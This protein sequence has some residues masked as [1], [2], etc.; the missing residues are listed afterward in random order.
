M[1]LDEYYRWAVGLTIHNGLDIET[2]IGT[3]VVSYADVTVGYTR[4]NSEGGIH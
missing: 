1:K 4:C 2:L 3:E